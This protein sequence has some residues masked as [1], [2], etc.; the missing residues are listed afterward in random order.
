MWHD[1]AETRLFQPF[2]LQ[3]VKVPLVEWETC[4]T[5]YNM[6]DT[7]LCAGYFDKGGKD[8]CNVRCLCCQMQKCMTSISSHC[9]ERLLSEYIAGK[10][11]KKMIKDNCDNSVVYSVLFVHSGRVMC[12]Y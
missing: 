7:Q 8:S 12:G 1:V 3:K 2:Q 9:Q 4:Q 11:N 10:N 6:V 5:A